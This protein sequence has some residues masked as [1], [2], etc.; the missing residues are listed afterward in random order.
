MS[1]PS[2]PLKAVLARAEN[3]TLTKKQCYIDLKNRKINSSIISNYL[4]A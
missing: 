3:E 2:E 4:D 1:N